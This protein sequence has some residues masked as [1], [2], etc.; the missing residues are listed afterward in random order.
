MLKEMHVNDVTYILSEEESFRV[1]E[2]VKSE[3]KVETE[4]E[5]PKQNINPK[6][7]VEKMTDENQTE[8]N[9]ITM[10]AEQEFEALMAEQNKMQK[11]MESKK[12]GV[13]SVD[14]TVERADR[15]T[16]I[17]EDGKRK[18][19]AY[20]PRKGTSLFMARQNAKYKSSGK[21][22]PYSEKCIFNTIKRER[23]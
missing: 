12:G 6:Q 5:K 18:G 1:E 10:T 7:E 8:E 23:A 22:A 14:D 3:L 20:K 19:K 17:T 21:P 11:S 9:I 16:Q 4:V 13:T 2:E 15:A